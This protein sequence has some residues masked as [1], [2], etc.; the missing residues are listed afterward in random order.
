M[1]V[2]AILCDGFPTSSVPSKRTEPVDPGRGEAHDGRAQRRLAHAV[3]AEDG[4]RLL[5]D[6]EVDVLED[7]GAAVERVEPFDLEEDAHSRA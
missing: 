6:R 5:A 1:P 3:A 2:R 4:D 7:V